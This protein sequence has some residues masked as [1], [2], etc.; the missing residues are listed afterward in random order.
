[1]TDLTL[2][3]SNINFLEDLEHTL[4][5]VNK[6]CFVDTTF[7]DKEK[8]I[9]LET[10]ELLQEIYDENLEAKFQ[11]LY[12]GV[13]TCEWKIPS[14]EDTKT[15]YK[16]AKER[17]MAFTYVTP[18]SGGRSFE[19]IKAILAFLN[20]L[21]DPVEVV[22]NDWGILNLIDTEY[23]KLI[24]I[25]GRL[26]I[27]MKRDP[28]YSVVSFQDSFRESGLEELLPEDADCDLIKTNQAKFLG[29][30]SL[31]FP[32]Y[33]DFLK[34]KR[35][36]RVEL[37]LISTDI[38]LKTDFPIDIFW[39]WTYVT[40]GR[41]C[42]LGYEGFNHILE[43]HCSLPCESQYFEFMGEVFPTFSKGNAI[44]MYSPLELLK[45]YWTS[46]AREADNKDKGWLNHVVFDRVI[47]QPYIPI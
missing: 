29:S 1:M 38:T 43:K 16:I 12:F 15:A 17:E 6:S 19:K 31:S 7:T 36:A 4:R 30:C 42:M 27:K 40:S 2:F 41:A 28:R 5:R 8:I 3:L 34:S 9:N 46:P 44:W 21:P 32:Q 10:L 25:L 39:P 11:R 45:K 13:E 18:Y 37:D 35:I 47:Y 33:Q 14:L 23:E 22:V 26:M 20:G 24:P